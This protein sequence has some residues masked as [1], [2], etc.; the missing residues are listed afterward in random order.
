MHAQNMSGQSPKGFFYVPQSK[1]A[2]KQK[3]KK[4][5]KQGQAYLLLS[6]VIVSNLLPRFGA[7]LAHDS[8]NKANEASASYFQCEIIHSYRMGFISY[9]CFN[10]LQV[11]E[12]KAV[13]KKILEVKEGEKERKMKWYKSKRNGRAAADGLRLFF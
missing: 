12:K 11:Q 2:K 9:K 10:F 1:N 6:A 3:C 4:A 8:T 7:H 13:R 5:K